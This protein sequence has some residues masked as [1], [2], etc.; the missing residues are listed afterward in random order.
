M[1]C[2]FA[3]K[4]PQVSS[5]SMILS[6]PPRFEEK[7][8]KPTIS[9][10]QNS[11]CLEDRDTS[12]NFRLHNAELSP[13]SCRGLLLNRHK[14]LQMTL[15]SLETKE[16]V[17][18]Q[19]ARQDAAHI[20]QSKLV[21]KIQICQNHLFCISCGNRIL[22]RHSSFYRVL[23][24]PSENW[25]D[26][27][28]MWFCHRHDSHG[29]SDVHDTT[30]THDQQKSKPSP[31]LSPKANDCLVGTTYIMINSRHIQSGAVNSHQDELVCSRCGVCIGTSLTHKQSDQETK[32]TYKIYLHAT[33]FQQTDDTSDLL[34]S[35]QSCED[36]LQYYLSQLLQEESQLYTSF[37]FIIS[38]T[39][40]HNLSI[41]IMVWLLDENIEVYQGVCETTSNI[42]QVIDIPAVLCVKLLYRCILSSSQAKPEDKAIYK[43]WERDNSVHGISLPYSLCQQMTS[44]LI[45]STKKLPK[46]TR[47]LNGFNIGLL[48]VK[49]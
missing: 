28:D 2:L 36:R 11:V 15:R 5:V 38:S 48:N 12:V 21:E 6:L 14:D 44:I 39:D 24:L 26:Y 33:T 4:K 43:L 7:D 3:E 25:S 31:S 41:K 8:S 20:N 17:I 23:P 29:A 19:P 27:A 9:V 42:N 40:N 49:R 46:S 22:H 30:D 1:F 10:H 32:D 13:L 16:D 37:R 34:T 18:I 47:Q 35:K 45:N